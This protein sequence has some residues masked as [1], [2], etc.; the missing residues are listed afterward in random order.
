[1]SKYGGGILNF[2]TKEIS[3]FLPKNSI[4]IKEKACW[5]PR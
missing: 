5:I 1:M 3:Y 2:S 4:I